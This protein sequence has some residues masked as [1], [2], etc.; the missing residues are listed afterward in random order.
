MKYI[1][2]E[3]LLTKYPSKLSNIYLLNYSDFFPING[4]TRMSFCHFIRTIF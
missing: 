1:N 3:C 2:T 4:M